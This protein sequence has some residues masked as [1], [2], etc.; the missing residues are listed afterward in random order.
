MKL[1]TNDDAYRVT[2]LGWTLALFLVVAG[3][4]LGLWLR[5]QVG[6]FMLA[7]PGVALVV[8]L[9]SWP[10]GPRPPRTPDDWRHARQ[11]ARTV[12]IGLSLTVLIVDIAARHLF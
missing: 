3:F 4:A 11:R 12:L 1:W 5:G 8:L 9:G 6:G 2:A 10:P 7:C